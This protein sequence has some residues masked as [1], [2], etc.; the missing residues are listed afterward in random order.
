MC[1]ESRFPQPFPVAIHRRWRG[2]RWLLPGAAITTID[3]TAIRA[4]GAGAPGQRMDAD[5]WHRRRPRYPRAAEPAEPSASRRRTRAARSIEPI[6]RAHRRL[7]ERTARSVGSCRL[8]SIGRHPPVCALPECRWVETGSR[9]DRSAI[10]T[11]GARSIGSPQKPDASRRNRE[12]PGR[13]CFAASGFCAPA[14]PR[15]SAHHFFLICDG[16]SSVN[17]TV[18]G[19]IRSPFSPLRSLPL[20][21]SHFRPAS[22]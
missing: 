5:V 16:S 7:A 20:T 21:S 18:Y 10:S 13:P 9:C 3:R 17:S 22:A 11:T 12:R 2:A 8:A 6:Y 15:A 4:A 1:L 14:L 19:T